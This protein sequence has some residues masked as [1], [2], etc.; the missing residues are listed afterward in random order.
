MTVRL[1]VGDCRAVLPTLAAESMQCVAT[2]P[3]YWGLRDYG[4][5]TW[6][7]GDKACDHVQKNAR[8]DV[9][10][11][12][13]A[14]RAALY[15]TGTQDGSKVTPMLFRD[16]CGKCGAVRVDSQLGLERTPE[17][18][19]AN[20][21]AVFREVRRIL[22]NDG[23]CFVNLGDSYMPNKQLAGIPWRFALAM[24]RSGWTLRSDIVWSKPNPMPESVTDRPT[25]SHEFIFMF[26]KSA[27]VG[28][29]FGHIEPD[30]ARWLALFLDTEGNLCLRRENGRDGQYGSHSAQVVLANSS[31]ALL[32]RAREIVGDGSIL[33]RGGKNAPMYYWQVC[34][35]KAADLLAVVYPH[36]IVKQRQAKCLLHLESRKSY[37]G[38][39]GRLSAEEIAY[40][41]RLWQSVKSLNHFGD[42]DLSWVPE[43]LF[44]LAKS[45]TYFYDA[46]AI[47]EAA[48]DSTLERWGAR[49]V[50]TGQPRSDRQTYGENTC[51]VNPAGRNKRSVW[52]VATSPYSGAHFAT[53]PPKLIEPCIL[54]GTSARGA[55]EHCGAPWERVVEQTVTGKRHVSPKD[56]NPARNDGGSVGS[57]RLHAQY[58]DYQSTTLGWRPTCACYGDLERIG[59]SS[60]AG[61]KPCV[62]LDPFGGAGTT[63]LVA[64]RLGRDA[65]LVELNPEY[66]ALGD[67]RMTDDAPLF[68]DV[69]RDA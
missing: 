57:S 55:C 27:S 35:K 33:Q 10:P 1:L 43:P 18:Y 3:P 64:D 48:S 25:K 4:T 47:R 29:R 56:D 61:T 53:F 16:V 41:D 68:A 58:F 59:T 50:R 31:V 8:N 15:G 36:L 52:T 44:L 45:P 34:G 39:H 14:E 32:E 42:P 22:R 28:G 65:V 24:Q 51:G 67:D 2:S 21:V 20:M 26:C 13:L 46:D 69:R 37:R 9:T 23:T 66:A 62:V 49:P 5:A 63:G 38:G 60:N 12:R 19:V 17:E 54:A 30:D 7:G 40:R 11:E 6:D